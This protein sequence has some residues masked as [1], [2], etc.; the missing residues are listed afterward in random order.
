MQFSV[1]EMQFSGPAP[2]EPDI[3]CVPFTPDRFAE[4][5][6]LYNACF[7]EMRTALQRTPVD[8]LQNI[9]QLSND[10][11]FLLLKDDTIAGAV[12]LCKNEIDGLIVN[13]AC[14]RRGYGS[15][16]LRWA[17]ACIRRK[18]DAPITLHVAAWN[19]NAL[20][21]YCKTGFVI[22]HTEIIQ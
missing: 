18:N 5:K 21:L 11:I 7:R 19:Q 16:L 14:R 17:M 8:W 6:Q 4:Y 3:C 12:T 9:S 10:E 13:E 1:H 15:Q 22:T 2:C 20:R